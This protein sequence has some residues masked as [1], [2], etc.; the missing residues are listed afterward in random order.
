ML[1]QSSSIL[2]WCQLHSARQQSGLLC[3]YSESESKQVIQGT[4]RAAQ[5]AVFMLMKQYR[6]CSRPGCRTCAHV[7]ELMEKDLVKQFK[8]KPAF[9]ADKFKLEVDATLSDLSLGWNGFTVEEFGFE[10]NMCQNHTTG[11]PASNYLQVKYYRTREIYDQVN[12]LMVR[13]AKIGVEDIVD[14]AHTAVVRFLVE[15]DDQKGA[16]YWDKTWALGSGHG[17]WSALHGQYGGFNTNASL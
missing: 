1:A 4:F 8:A 14:K 9:T 10:P 2:H 11:I 5:S 15:S 17:R 7:A 16:H 6:V 13:I 3:C 12:D